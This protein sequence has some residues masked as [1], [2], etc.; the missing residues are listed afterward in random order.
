[1]AGLCRSK[2]M[3]K[4]D[5]IVALNNNK[6]L[7]KQFVSRMKDEEINKRIKDYWTIHEHLDHLV[8]CQKMMIVRIQ[9]FIVEEKPEI[10]P[11]IPDDKPEIENKN[12]TAKELVNEFIKLRDLQI[13]LIV[14]SK[15]NVWK[16]VGIHPEYRKYNFEI[17]LRHIVMHDGFHLYRM[18]ELWI[19]NEDLIHELK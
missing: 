2:I 10:K 16:K 7:L 6:K 17:L 12:K 3:L 19:E 8:V 9:Q 14:K 5:L 13:R 15:R 11:Y 18:E 1:M 4:R